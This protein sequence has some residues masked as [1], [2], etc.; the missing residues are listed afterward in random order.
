VQDL[1]LIPPI[2]VQEP[3]NAEKVIKSLPIL[4]SSVVNLPLFLLLSYPLL[5]LGG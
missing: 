3:P 4:H 2:S 1:H 5:S